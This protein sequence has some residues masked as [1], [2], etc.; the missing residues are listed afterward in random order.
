MNERPANNEGYIPTDIEQYSNCISHLFLFASS[1]LYHYFDL[2]LRPHYRTVR[3]GLHLIDRT[4]IYVYIAAS[5]IPWIAIKQINDYFRLQ[6][7]TY[8][9]AFIGILYQWAYHERH[10]TVET[11]LYITSSVAPSMVIFSKP[12]FDQDD[13][14]DIYCL[15]SA[16]F[17]YLIGVVFFKLDGIIPFAHTI[18]HFHVILG[19]PFTFSFWLQVKM[20]T[21]I[22]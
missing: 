10:K 12:I 3:H 4:S 7:L 2:I 13:Y 18:W 8:L 16:G 20:Q 22:A 6:C 11:I 9:T 14:H 15:A 17:I 21:K 1:S 5:Y 19:Q